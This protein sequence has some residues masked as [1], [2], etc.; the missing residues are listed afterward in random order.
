M[1]LSADTVQGNGAGMDPYSYVGGN[2]ET[3]SDP[4]GQRAVSAGDGSSDGASTFVPTSYNPPSSSPFQFTPSNPCWDVGCRYG[5]Y[6]QISTTEVVWHRTSVDSTGGVVCSLVCMALQYQSQVTT[7]T[8]YRTDKALP[9]QG[10]TLSLVSCEGEKG[11]NEEPSQG[12]RPAVDMAAD[13]GATPVEGGNPTGDQGGSLPKQAQTRAVEIRDIMV[14]NNGWWFRK[15]A[16][17]GVAYMQDSEGGIESYV[18]INEGALNKWGS[19]VQN[20]LEPGEQ[21]IEGDPSGK[22]HPEVLLKNYAEKTRQKIIGLGASTGFCDA[23]SI[24]LLQEVGQE[25]LG[26]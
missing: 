12:E 20:H 14:K 19:A 24:M 9:V 16:T 17:V 23:C 22:V 26:Q 5:A 13:E 2:P 11:R 21:W 7:Y 25:Y 10:C 15:E 1:F 6:L 18:A 3:Y 4:S 8:I